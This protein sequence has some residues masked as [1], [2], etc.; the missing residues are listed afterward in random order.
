MS[1]A[2]IRHLLR[3]SKSGLSLHSL[4]RCDGFMQP[5]PW[6]QV[7]TSLG[8]C[9]RLLA[10]PTPPPPPP[11]RQ[12]GS[13]AQQLGAAL[14]TQS[15][16]TFPRLSRCCVALTCCCAPP[17]GILLS[18]QH[19]K[20]TLSCWPWSVHCGFGCQHV[21]ERGTQLS[22]LLAASPGL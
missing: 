17:A 16:V 3:V 1:L 13:F 9:C 11:P 2:V 5:A 12:T 6:S 22:V 4:S 19:A 14:K 21:L 8:H 10:T 15:G 7:V 18:L 20:G